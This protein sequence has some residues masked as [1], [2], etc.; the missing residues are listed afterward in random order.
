MSNSSFVQY[1]FIDAT[2]D[3]HNI[4]YS[5]NSN[6]L[7][8]YGHVSIQHLYAVHTL[9]DSLSD[10]DGIDID[11]VDV[12]STVN[13][14]DYPLAT[15]SGS[16]PVTDSHTIDEGSSLS[17]TTRSQNIV[18][19]QYSDLVYYLETPT[20]PEYFSLVEN[21]NSTLTINLTCSM[22]G[23]ILLKHELVNYSNYTVPTWVTLDDSNFQLS[24]STPQV[25]AD[26]DYYFQIKTTEISDSTTH[27]KLVNLT[28]LN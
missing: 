17:F 19:D 14:S 2:I 8:L 24:L 9:V 23:S 28:V 25:A 7:L 22:S 5:T 16:S 21:W 4:V 10:F 3:I 26:S 18:I 12:F 1:K 27:F 13:L 15:D 6:C 11:P 20:D